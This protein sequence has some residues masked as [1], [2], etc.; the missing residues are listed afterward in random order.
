[1]IIKGW[2]QCGLLRAFEKSFRV[3]VQFTMEA[4]CSLFASTVDS[5]EEINEDHDE[6]DW[7]D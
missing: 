2:G 7:E 4:H 6:E 5:G 1:M 3:Q